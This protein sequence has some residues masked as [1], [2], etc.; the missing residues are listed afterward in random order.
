MIL[1]ESET[2]FNRVAVLLHSN[3]H[4]DDCPLEHPGDSSARA[5]AVASPVLCE[6][7]LILRTRV[8]HFRSRTLFWRDGGCGRGGDDLNPAPRNQYDAEKKSRTNM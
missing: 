2:S 5:H 6:Q 3:D 1:Y 8:R 7:L 4:G